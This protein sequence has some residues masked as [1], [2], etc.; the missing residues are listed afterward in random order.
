M[1]LKM[2]IGF[3]NGIDTLTEDY[4][5]S[6]GDSI[7]SLRFDVVAVAPTGSSYGVTDLMAMLRVLMAERFGLRTHV[8][9]RPMPVYSLTVE[10]AGKLGPGL[11]PSQCN[12]H[13][14]IINGNLAIQRVARQTAVS[15]PYLPPLESN[16][17]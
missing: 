3:V 9:N 17:V 12:C 15:H 2:L 6:G 5:I 11:R 4:R 16:S 7:L 10:R 14:L 8:E 13:D 1:P